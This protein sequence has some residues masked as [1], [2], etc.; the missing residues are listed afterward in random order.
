M[1]LLRGNHEVGRSLKFMVE[2]FAVSFDGLSLFSMYILCS[3]PGFYEE[4]TRKY[5]TA[6]VW[7]YCNDVF[8]LLS[9]ASVSSF[10]EAHSIPFSLIFPL[11]SFFFLLLVSLLFCLSHSSL[12]LS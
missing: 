11:L 1:T 5:G 4:C 7:K 6:N 10:I 12:S 3:L 9:L 2:F 8:D